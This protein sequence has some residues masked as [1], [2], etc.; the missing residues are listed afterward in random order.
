[1]IKES[2][3]WISEETWSKIKAGAAV[4]GLAV[5]TIAICA[6]STFAMAYAHGFGNS[7]G[8]KDGRLASNG[9]SSSGSFGGRDYSNSIPIG[10]SFR[11]SSF[12]EAA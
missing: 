5:A 3:A 12:D 8:W 1:M 9:D 4:A 7:K 10:G 6:V 11:R 2:K